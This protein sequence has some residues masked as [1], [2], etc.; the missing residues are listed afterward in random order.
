MDFKKTA[1]YLKAL[2]TFDLFIHC[3]VFSIVGYLI[4]HLLK[5]SPELTLSWE[6]EL[7]LGATIALVVALVQVCVLKVLFQIR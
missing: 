2:K 6:K 3:F 1:A 7:L 4:L 5:S